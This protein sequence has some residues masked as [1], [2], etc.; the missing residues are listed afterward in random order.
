MSYRLW[1]FLSARVGYTYRFSEYLDPLGDEQ[2]YSDHYIDGGL[3]FNKAWQFDFALGPKTTF[4]FGFGTS[5]TTAVREEDLQVYFNVVGNA[6]FSH[7]FNDRWQFQSGYNRWV[8][9]QDGITDPWISD[10]VYATFGGYFNRRVSVSTSTAYASGSQIGGPGTYDTW[11]SSAQLQVALTRNI[12]TFAQYFYY[13]YFY[14]ETRLPSGVPPK[15]DRQGVRFGLT[16]W[17]PLLR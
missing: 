6:L 15:F 10:V 11:S 2:S 1:S 4:S 16:F 13:R 7:W 5:F 14:E 17:V 8:G 3:D 9:F 12:A